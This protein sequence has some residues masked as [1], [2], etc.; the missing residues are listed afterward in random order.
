MTTDK[1]R[2]GLIDFS[3]T[4]NPDK[5]TQGSGRRR[6]NSKRRSSVSEEVAVP[7]KDVERLQADRLRSGFSC[8]DVAEVMGLNEELSHGGFVSRA[9]SGRQRIST[10]DYRQIF[11]AL[12]KLV[13]RKILEA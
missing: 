2:Q 1:N 12:A 7:L 10:E 6:S 5:K 8:S 13:F 3:A 11:V 9:L 4:F